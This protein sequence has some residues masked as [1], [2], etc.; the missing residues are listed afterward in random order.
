MRQSAWGQVCS[1]R[2]ANVSEFGK[3]M[4]FGTCMESTLGFRGADE[5]SCAVCIHVGV[6]GE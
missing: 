1:C 5:H 2:D 6:G 3:G 4:C